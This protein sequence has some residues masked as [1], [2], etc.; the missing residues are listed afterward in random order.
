MPNELKFDVEFTRD[1][2]EDLLKDPAVQYVNV[3]GTYTHLGQNSWSTLA[4]AYGTDNKKD[5][6][7]AETKQADCIKPC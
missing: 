6:T 5:R 1:Q 3:S 7:A 2:I 4:E